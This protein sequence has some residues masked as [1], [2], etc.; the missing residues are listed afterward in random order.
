MKILYDFVAYEVPK[1]G[2]FLIETNEYKLPQGW[3][4]KE[5]EF[6]IIGETDDCFIDR[7][8]PSCHGEWIGDKV[9]QRKFILPIGV[10]K[11]RFV[12]WTSG[13]L[14]LFK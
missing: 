11:S 9:V 4:K 12:R 10:H 6:T 3:L 14:T 5:E 7:L 13:Q 8:L 2:I 1:K